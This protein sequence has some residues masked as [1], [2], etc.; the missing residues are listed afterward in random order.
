MSRTI[1]VVIINIV[2]KQN[3]IVGKTQV[4]ILKQVFDC[5]L[6]SALTSDRTRHDNIIKQLQIKS[7]LICC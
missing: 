3:K 7:L 6:S 4:A 5:T 1:D 2:S